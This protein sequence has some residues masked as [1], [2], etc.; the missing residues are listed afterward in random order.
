MHIIRDKEVH[1][2]GVRGC[3]EEKKK[4]GAR[5]GGGCQKKLGGGGCE[6]KGGGRFFFGGGG[7]GG[8]VRASKIPVF[9]YIA[10]ISQITTF[11]YIVT[12][13]KT[14]RSH[15]RHIYMSLIIGP[16]K[17]VNHFNEDRYFKRDVTCEIFQT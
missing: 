14:Y 3:C 12:M 11:P 4:R 10:S 2:T 13:G 6:K 8:G 7:G 16:F 17:Y 1:N 9:L 15:I 5:G